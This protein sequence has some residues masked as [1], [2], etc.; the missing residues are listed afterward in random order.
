MDFLGQ[1]LAAVG[2]ALGIV[3]ILMRMGKSF[4]E[5]W[6]ETNIETTAEKSLSKYTNLLEQLAE[7]RK[8]FYLRDY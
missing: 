2:G 1:L 4:I 8:E 7:L 5:K 3:L 6:V